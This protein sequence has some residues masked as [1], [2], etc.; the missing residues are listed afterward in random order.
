MNKLQNLILIPNTTKNIEPVHLCALLSHLKSLGCKIGVFS[1]DIKALAE[2][3]VEFTEIKST[4]D[5]DIY[6]AAVVLGGDGSIIEASHRLLGKNI[7]IIGINFGHI[8]FLTELEA[9]EITDIGKA[10]LGEYTLE[11]R[12]MLDAEIFN[13]E[14][15]LMKKFTVLNDVVMTNGPIARLISFD[16]SCDGIKIETCRADGIIAA[17]PTGSTAYS[18]SAGGPVLNPLIDCIC[19]TPICPHTLSSRPVIFHSGSEINISGIKANNSSVYL[20]AD[21]RDIIELSDGWSV[22]IKRSQNETVLIRIKERGFLSVLHKK[23][24]ENL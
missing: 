2:C 24:S 20:N 5:A 22:K 8:G 10:V 13:A 4:S 9:G 18:L 6:D 21:G 19:L 17:T 12:M 7:P 15:N 11:R 23:L 3:D 16:I 14:N 1:T